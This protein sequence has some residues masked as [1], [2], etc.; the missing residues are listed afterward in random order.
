MIFKDVNCGYR[1]CCPDG[2]MAA[3]IEQID[4]VCRENGIVSR[5]LYCVDK[6]GETVHQMNAQTIALCEQNQ[7]VPVLRLLP[8]AFSDECYSVEEIEQLAR[9]KRAA[10]RIHPKLD[11]SPMKEWMFP[12]V[13]SVLEKTGAPLLIAL[14]EADMEDMARLKT[15]YPDLVLVLTN[16]TQ[17]M[18]RQYVQFTKAF[19]NVYLDI[20]NVIEYYGLESLVKTVGADKLLFGTGMPVKE[21]YDKI[22][23]ILYSDLSEEERELI[24][25]QNFER[26]IERGGA[27]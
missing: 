18:N 1:S 17:W 24:A 26:V 12:G 23:Q 6:N 13:F 4:G 11:A 25:F 16:T 8:S 19:P 20:S 10:F 3:T 5:A 22:Y 7:D 15:A 2:M 14:E 9:E 21:P 27:K